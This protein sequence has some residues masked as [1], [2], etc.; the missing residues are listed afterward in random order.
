MQYRHHDCR[1]LQWCQLHDALRRDMA[2]TNTTKSQAVWQPGGAKENSCFRE[3]D[4]HLRL[5]YDDEEEEEDRGTDRQTDRDRETDRLRQKQTESDGDGYGVT[6]SLLPPPPPPPPP[7]PLLTPLH[8]QR[9][10]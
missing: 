1:T 5:I 6:P 4:R 8:P 3:G 10:T 7:P 2:R 9:Q